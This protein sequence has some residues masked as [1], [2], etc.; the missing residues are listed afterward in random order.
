MEKGKDKP[1]VEEITGDLYPKCVEY[2]KDVQEE[3]A[4][5][6]TY[7]ELD[8]A[9]RLELP[10]EF[11]KEGIV[12]PT[13]RDMVDTFVDH[14]DISNARVFVNRKGTSNQSADEVEMMRKF[15]LGLI[16]RNNVEADISPWRVG[17]KYYALHGLTVFEDVWDADQW[18]DKPDR[19]PGE[20]EDD[21]AARIDEWRARQYDSIPIVIRAIN[22]AN[23]I[24][25]PS[26]G[27]RSFVFKVTPKVVLDIQ[28]RYK[29]WGNPK[30]RKIGDVVNLI[31]Y[32]DR[33]YRCELADGEPLL[34]T[35]DGIVEHKYGFLPYV[36]IDSGLGNMNQKGEAK[37]RYVGTLRYIFD[38]LVAESR[39]FSI[40]D[41]VLKREAWPTKDLMG[42]NAGQV[43]EYSQEY[44]ALNRLP[45]GVE[46]AERTHAVPPD[47]LNAHMYR[48]SDY[49]SAHAAPRSVRGLGETGVRS[50]ADRRLMISEAASRYRYSEDAFKN[51][52]AKVL[53]N[54]ARL[55]K[56]VIPGN[57]R[58]WAKTPTDEF[59]VEIDKTKMK[60]PFTCY[61]EFAPISEEDEY[62]RHD[63]LERL[64]TSGIVTKRWARGQMSNVDPVA[65]EIDEER[66][67]LRNDPNLQQVV[68]QYVT[69]KLYAAIAARQAAD[70]IKTLPPMPAGMPS[71]AGQPPGSPAL[72][73]EP[74]RALVPPIPNV[75]PLGSA[76]AIQ[77][78]MAGLRSQ[79]PINQQGTG[80][81]GN[82]P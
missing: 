76:G 81:G 2:Y 63:D 30:S 74:G 9:E 78:Q 5:D 65:M 22:P 79:Q 3:F 34:Q 66:E 49:I 16:H 61:V 55:M 12:L 14:I 71:P 48:T 59:D 46:I 38:L 36:F 51:G 44:G 77:N 13:A 47:A 1:T 24:P 41:I 20:S 6:E 29:K 42:K 52:T 25:D 33:K 82:R 57:M 45:E 54:C 80:G 64:V 62:R 18:L 72:A 11:S 26:Y 15:Y 35:A 32:W 4:K 8:F 60:E 53:T 40:S 10:I 70:N 73:Q 21:Y 43:T 58:V 19:D 50:G 56:N 75:A 39:D 67:K 69:G 23:V 31:S 17:A 37:R 7:Y 27:G 68:S 28:R